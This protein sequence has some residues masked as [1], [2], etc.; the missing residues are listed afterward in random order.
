MNY[1]WLVSLLGL[2]TTSNIKKIEFKQKPQQETFPHNNYFNF[3][4]Q[5]IHFWIYSFKNNQKWILKPTHQVLQSFLIVDPGLKLL[6]LSLQGHSVLGTHLPPSSNN[7]S[8]QKQPSTQEALVAFAETRGNAQ[9][10]CESG[11]QAL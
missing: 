4:L 7:P 8:G 5:K 9:L 2:T 6:F 11:P 3:F 1:F 10:G